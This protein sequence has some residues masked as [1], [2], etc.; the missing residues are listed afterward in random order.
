M[1]TAGFMKGVEPMCEC[2]RMFGSLARK[3]LDSSVR[4]CKSAE[5]ADVYLIT[6]TGPKCHSL[7]SGS[8]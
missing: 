8:V 3:Y 6:G 5:G 2:R 7:A 1:R 4:P